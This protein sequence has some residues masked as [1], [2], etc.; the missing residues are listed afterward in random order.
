MVYLLNILII[1]A[2]SALSLGLL[3][4][5]SAGNTA[6]LLPL[7]FV[8][9]LSYFRRGFEPII[10]AAFSGLI[11]DIFSAYQFGFYLL[12]FLATA[13]VV[14]IAYSEG[15]KEVSFG[16]YL[17][18]AVLTILPYFALQVLLLRLA[19]VSVDYLLLP[20]PFLYLIGF[21]LLTG[22]L[23]YYFSSWYFDKVKV[24]E[25]YQKRR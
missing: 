23:M 16:R 21:G 20:L 12:F 11:L 24:L 4:Y 15:L 14:K 1:F 5:L 13:A 17:L 3:P 22:G 9:S 10:L 19:D 8:I 18:L 6:A 7:F 25:N 2:L